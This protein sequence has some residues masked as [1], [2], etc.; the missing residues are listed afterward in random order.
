MP[1]PE[2][3][4]D[5]GK[6]TVESPATLEENAG[7][8]RLLMLLVFVLAHYQMAKIGFRRALG[9]RPLPPPKP[10][11]PPPPPP[12]RAFNEP[13]REDEWQAVVAEKDSATR[14][15][16]VGALLATLTQ[17]DVSVLLSKAL[18]K[19]DESDLSR[20]M[21]YR[22]THEDDSR[23][24]GT[25]AYSSW[26]SLL[27]AEHYQHWGY[28]EPIPEECDSVPDV[29]GTF[30]LARRHRVPI[31]SG[32]YLELGPG[33]VPCQIGVFDPVRLRSEGGSDRVHLRV[34]VPADDGTVYTWNSEIEMR[35]MFRTLTRLGER[36]D[37]RTG[38][39]LVRSLVIRDHDRSVM[40]LSAWCAGRPLDLSIIRR[41][42]S[43]RCDV[44][45]LRGGLDAS[46]NRQ[47]DRLGLRLYPHRYGADGGKPTPV[48]QYAYRSIVTLMLPN[49]PPS[50]GTVRPRP[51]FVRQAMSRPK[52]GVEFLSGPRATVSP[53]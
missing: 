13:G 22:L 6:E 21:L 19:G 3:E 31:L 46:G 14:D 23:L 43:F 44:V 41:H 17:D 47:P 10:P 8:A 1:P 24:V 2:T 12:A 9:L 27:S 36:D 42:L 20:E 35:T 28:P 26:S 16:A 25:E 33:E 15:T 32:G 50:M 11:T 39:C 49:T 4:F 51:Y 48:I 37:R 52:S 7:L 45:A 53:E 29:N 5:A 30:S 34:T 18:H 40:T 38:E